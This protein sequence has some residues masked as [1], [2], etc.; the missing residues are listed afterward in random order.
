MTIFVSNFPTMP[1]K[2]ECFEATI[3]T[4]SSDIFLKAGLTANTEY[5]W[6]LT[7]RHNNVYQRKVTTDEDGTLVMES[8][9]LPQGLNKYSGAL[10]LSIRKGDD[11]LQVVNLTFGEETY[12][13]VY[14][15]LENFDR[16]ESDDSEVNYIQLKVPA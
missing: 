1:C 7:D 10:N 8:A 4:C 9:A 2:K 6:V 14:I 12:T 15:L 13:C 16:E 11:Y 5:Y 3:S